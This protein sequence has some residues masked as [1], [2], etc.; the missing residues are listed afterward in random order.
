MALAM[1]LALAQPAAAAESAQPTGDPEAVI[2]EAMAVLSDSSVSERWAEGAEAVTDANADEVLKAVT[3]ARAK[4]DAALSA[5]TKA[6]HHRFLVNRCI[7]EARSLH[8]AGDRELRRVAERAEDAKRE[9]RTKRIEERRAKAEA[10]PKRAPMERHEPTL[11]EPSNPID[12]VPKEVKEASKPMDLTPKEVK[13]PSKPVDVRPA[14]VKAETPEAERKALEE[15]NLRAFEER[16]QRAAERMARAEE[17][18][19][20]RRAERE[21]NR[22][23][24]EESLKAR[25][26]AQKRYEA[27]RSSGGNGR[28][29]LSEFF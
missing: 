8:F 16:K 13:E 15:A 6:C 17:I 19:A 14:E 22:K 23:Q 1:T 27:D 21:E 20:K 26:E 24:F 5:A 12:L 11:K 7:D 28:Q 25:E 3:E 29:S 18:A 2:S 4:K 9:A 10:E